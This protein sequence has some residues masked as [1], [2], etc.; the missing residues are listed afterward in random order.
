MA[1][2]IAF[3]VLALVLEGAF[4]Y[5]YVSYDLGGFSSKQ[6]QKTKSFIFDREKTTLADLVQAAYS[7]AQEYYDRSVDIEAL[8]RDKA[9]E[10]KVLIEALKSQIVAYYN[11]NKDLVSGDELLDNIKE[12][13]RSMRFS[14]GNYVW[15][16][17]MQPAMVMHPTQPKLDGKDLSGFKDQE[18]KALFVDMVEVCKKHGQGMVSYLW[19]KPGEAEAKPK[20]S[21][22]MLIP[23]LGWIIGTGA[24]VEDISSRLKAEAL[25][26][27]GEMRMG[28]G[29]YFWV[30][31]LEPRMVM[32]PI[33]PDLNGKPLAEYKDTQGKK[34]FVEFAEVCKR[35]GQGFVEYH[36][37]KPGKEGD[38]PKLSFV[39]L[40][41]PWGWVI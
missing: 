34:L 32:H 5:L 37:G 4:S 29:N 16:N 33:K 15:I 7:I 18:G 10:L 9:E 2:L 21:Y 28:D 17:D 6:A 36:W 40:F 25:A 11:K 30:N 20:V 26:Q 24:W 35:D 22:V 38:F 23:E 41:K 31:D 3:V 14:G 39:K 27:I 13:V 1:R 8:K 12:L 19:E